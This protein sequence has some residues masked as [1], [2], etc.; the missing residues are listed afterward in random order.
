MPQLT[1]VL[2]RK[3]MQVYDLDQTTV[4]IG[5]EAGMD[6]IIDNPSVSRA[7]AE[8]RKEGDGW[9]VTD[10]GSANG[11]F[12]NGDRIAS[13]RPLKAGDEIGIGKFSILFEKTVAA[14][15]QAS[16]APP[17]APTDEHQGTMQIKAHEVTKLLDDYSKQ[18]R[19]HIEWESGGQKGTHHFT[20]ASAVL[21]GTDDLCD[22]RVPKGPKHH[23]LV[24]RKDKG[25][26]IKNL[27]LLGKMRVGGSAARKARL[28]DGDVVEM[29]G[30][31]LTFV[32]DLAGS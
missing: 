27:A 24:I 1:L 32:G 31:K 2:G 11:T 30:V 19:A 17:R 10:L 8:L 4:R 23:L 28:K 18:R 16:A 21:I 12:L 5:R 26:E 25:C 7:Q 3:P 29:S 22:V 14:A 9:T 6:I 13:T 20:D 15:P